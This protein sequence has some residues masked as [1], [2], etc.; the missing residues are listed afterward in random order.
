MNTES[1]TLHEHIKGVRQVFL[2]QAAITAAK[3]IGFLNITR[4]HIA[5]EAG[6]SP[7]LVSRYLGDMDNIRTVIMKEAVRLEILPIIAQGLA[8]GHPVATGVSAGL[9]VLAAESLSK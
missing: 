6:I 9:R 5:T 3:R 8:A 1:V 4:E 2:V 7:P